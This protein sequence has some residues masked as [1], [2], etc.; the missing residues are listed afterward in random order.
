MTWNE[1]F[2]K[3]MLKKKRF[4]QDHERHAQTNVSVD[5]TDEQ[6]MFFFFPTQTKLLVLQSPG[7]GWYFIHEKATGRA[8]FTATKLP[9]YTNGRAR[10]CLLPPCWRWQSRRWWKCVGETKVKKTNESVDTKAPTSLIS[11][12]ARGKQASIMQ[13]KLW[14]KLPLTCLK[15]SDNDGCSCEYWWGGA[16]LDEV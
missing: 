4:S 12:S 11:W 8:A 5:E 10:L 14:A 15:H 3:I 6:L 1:I 9:N 7:N 2:Y 16:N 13:Q